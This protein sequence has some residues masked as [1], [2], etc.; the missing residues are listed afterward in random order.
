MSIRRGWFAPG[1]TAA[2]GVVLSMLLMVLVSLAQNNGILQAVVVGVLLGGVFAGVT[3]AA[4]WYFHSQELHT[5]YVS[6]EEIQ[7]GQ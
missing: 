2:V 4:A 5:N 3:L 1:I 6:S 7:E